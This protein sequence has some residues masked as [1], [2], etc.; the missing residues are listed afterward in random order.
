[1]REIAFGSIT[2]LLL[3]LPIDILD[4]KSELSC[5]FDNRDVGV[6]EVRL[7]TW[8]DLVLDVSILSAAG[9]V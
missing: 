8:E 5:R 9:I 3:L 2:I 7:L 6:I 4:K 1:M